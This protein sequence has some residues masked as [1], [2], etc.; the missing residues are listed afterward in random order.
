M[1]HRLLPNHPEL[2]HG[3]Q[4][5]RP[6]FEG[7]YF[8]QASANTACIIPGV[9]RGTE[10]SEDIAFIQLIFSSGETYF[11]EYPYEAFHYQKD[12]FEVWIDRSFFSV[13]RVMLNIKHP[14][15]NVEGEL[16]YS[17]ITPLETS[18]FSPSIMGPFSYLPHMQ[19]NHGVLSLT[20]V[21]SGSLRYQNKQISFNNGYGYIEK[22]WGEAFPSHWLWMQ[23]ND[24]ESSA[25]FSIADIPV[26]PLTFKGLICVLL[27]N[28][29]QYRFATYNSGKVSSITQEDNRITVVVKRG[30]YQLNI[31]AK[32]NQFGVLK[33]PTKTGMNRDIDECVDAEFT[34]TLLRNSKK[35]FSRRYKNGGLEML[36]P[37]KLIKQESK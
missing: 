3:K 33:A 25:M 26:G 15:I 10:P 37:T 18:V 8:K 14:N 30:R 2:Y 16:F 6:Y 29:K 20:H 36:D 21:V 27:L 34:V 22:D 31:C 23:C 4:R 24:Y 28:G 13:K 17:G 19:C 1:G 7:W 32:G 11:I 5:S 12:R 35:L 9:Y